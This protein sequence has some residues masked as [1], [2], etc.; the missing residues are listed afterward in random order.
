M[1][2][3][4]I[5]A[6]GTGTRLWPASRTALAKQFIEFYS[7]QGTLFEATLARLQGLP[8]LASPIV[9]CGEEQRFLVAESLRRNRSESGYILLEPEGRNTAPAI[10]L[11]AQ[12][13]LE[14]DEQ[15]QL[16]VLPA[17]HVI[18]DGA[19]F[20]RAVTAGI[21]LAEQ[22]WLVTFGIVPDIPETGYGY[23]KSG[24]A[25]VGSS[26]N[27]VAEFVEKPDL[28]TARAYLETGDYRWNSGMF[29][30]KASVYLQ[31]LASHAPDIEACCRQ[32]YAGSEKDQDFIRIAE[33][34]FLACRSESIDYAVMEKTDRAA[35]LSLDAG[36]SDLGAWN[37]VW[38]HAPKDEQG[39]VIS[40]DVL[41]VAT[42]NSYIQAQS[43]LVAAL[44]VEDAV[45]VET[46]DAV[47][48][49][50]KARAQQVKD[51]VAQLQQLKRK[52]KDFH[53]LVHRPWGSFESLAGG[54]GYQVKHIVVNPGAAISLQRH[55]HRSEHWTVVRGT[56]LIYCDGREF[57]LNENESTFIPLGS[58]HRLSN[59]SDK[60]V[61][62]IEVQVGDYLGEDDI[63]RFEDL[64]GR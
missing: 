20:R 6:G 59:T 57:A 29:L 26:G 49:A 17:D 63:E 45:I 48:V 39:N 18:E 35:M 8:S 9:V 4:I 13:A 3:P 62:I 11:A 58:K 64:Y 54:V 60:P 44:G 47:L 5:L 28:E 24:E 12:L 38:E 42:G 10:A 56:A 23:L 31:E 37:A 55:Q 32:A 16:L 46:P 14:R 36:W 53:R 51:I 34:E 7:G 1:L 52:E 40:G 61:E 15:A 2:Y 22:D 50:D 33:S 43:R 21:E 19:A 27:R 25:I 41:S 30:F